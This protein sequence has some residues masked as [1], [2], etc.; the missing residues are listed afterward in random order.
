MA[1]ATVANL[2]ARWRPLTPAE[3][4][5]AGILLDDASVQLRRE[6]PTLAAR[7]EAGDTDLAAATVRVE[8]AMVKRAMSVTDDA[9]G[10]TSAQETTGP[11][12]R[13]YQYSNPMGDLYVTK[14]E[15]RLLGG[16]TQAAFAIDQAG[17]AHPHLLDDL[18]YTR[19]ASPQARLSGFEG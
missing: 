14:Q 9:I 3:E 1:Y 6:I 19:L 12:S 15:L 4:D 2:A 7:I 10:V 16:G 5:T 11:F 13:S 8:C 18:I 17:D